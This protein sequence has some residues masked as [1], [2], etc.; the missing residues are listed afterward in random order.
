[1]TSGRLGLAKAQQPSLGLQLN[2]QKPLDNHHVAPLIPDLSVPLVNPD[3]PKP[4]RREQA[5]AGVVLD[6]YPRD[7]FVQP[8]FGS[9]GEERLERPFAQ[10][11]LLLVERHINHKLGDARVARARAV[12]RGRRKRPDAG[13]VLDDNNR[14]RR[15]EPERH[16]FSA[17]RGGF[18]GC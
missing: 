7:Q 14:V 2:V 8:V 3:F 16:V 13:V 11:L 18:K 10:P 12:A 5:A 1:M 17:T 15:F 9:D 4:D 6:K